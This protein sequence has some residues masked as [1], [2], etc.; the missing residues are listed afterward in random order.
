MERNH[1]YHTG[2]L[3]DQGEMAFATGRDLV[4]AD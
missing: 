2:G 1:A 3:K 4:D